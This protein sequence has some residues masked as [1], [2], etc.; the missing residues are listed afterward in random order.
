MGY[1]EM[2]ENEELHNS[3]LQVAM[4][5]LTDFTRLTIAQK[6]DPGQLNP[7]TIT[8]LIYNIPSQA[9]YTDSQYNNICH[10][11]LRMLKDGVIQR[12]RMNEAHIVS[13]G[14][15]GKRIKG[16]PYRQ[17]YTITSLGKEALE[18]K[19]VRHSHIGRYP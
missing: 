3:Q 17:D 7:A 14:P 11:I 5:C 13:N 6:L 16:A 18:R 15:I 19:G 9:K 12:V 10:H 8:R 1:I 4:N 2:S